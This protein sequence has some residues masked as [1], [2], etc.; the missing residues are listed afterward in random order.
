VTQ[1]VE[2]NIDVEKLEIQITELLRLEL[3]IQGDIERQKH[4]L[5]RVQQQRGLLQTQV[6]LIRKRH[7]GQEKD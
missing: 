5:E 3:D 7:L 1:S 2:N 4:D 6:R